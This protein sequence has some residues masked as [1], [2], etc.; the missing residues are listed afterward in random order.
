MAELQLIEN[1]EYEG[2]KKKYIY[3]KSLL[4]AQKTSIFNMS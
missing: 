4:N 3:K 1:L 2:A